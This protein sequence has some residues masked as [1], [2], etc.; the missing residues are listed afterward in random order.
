M[1]VLFI[2]FLLIF[3]IHFAS[4]QEEY[5]FE[6]ITTIK[7]IF[8]HFTIDDL[9]QI[10]TIAEDND[11]VKYDI[12]GNELFRYSNNR[13]GDLYSLD[14]SNPLNILLFYPDQQTAITLDR[15]LSESGE[16]DLFG[17]ETLEVTAICLSIEN[18]LWVFDASN[19]RLKLID[20]RGIAYEESDDLSLYF[21]APPAIT[22][23]E[24]HKGYIY[25][26]VPESGI[27]LFDNYGNFDKELP[28]KDVNHFQFFNDKLYLQKKGQFSVLNLN[29]LKESAL[30]LPKTI[31]PNTTVKLKN[32][33]VI[34]LEGGHDIEVWRLTPDRH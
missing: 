30:K 4:G 1:R 23:M 32:N 16:F 28:V 15:T 6:K 14:V 33:Y 2:V 5:S 3:G 19:Y 18:K 10:Y 27:V 24:A 29:T 12:D 7:G 13:M 25:A 17:P 22:Q 11:I 21:D 34:Y 8:S 9:N 26:N 31:S 20:G